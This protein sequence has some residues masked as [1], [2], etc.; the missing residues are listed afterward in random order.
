MSRHRAACMTRTRFE[1]KRA[2]CCA[3]RAH[4][5]WQRSSLANGCTF[6]TST[7]WTR[8]ASGNWVTEVLLGEKLPRPPKE[9]PRLPED[10]TATDGLTVRQLVEKHTSDPKCA[11]CHQRIDPYGYA[12]EGFDAIGRRRDKD[13]SDRPIE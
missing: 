5:G 1:H 4:G 6:G 3:T 10:E 12:L 13:L 2:A 8:R 11:V 9:V 7:S